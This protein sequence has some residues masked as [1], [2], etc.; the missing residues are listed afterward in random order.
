MGNES[1]KYV[2]AGPRRGARNIA[3]ITKRQR[4]H[5]NLVYS[6]ACLCQSPPNTNTNSRYIS[7]TDQERPVE[8]VGSAP[9][10]SIGGLDAGAHPRARN[11]Q[12]PVESDP[13]SIELT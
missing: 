10:V 9:K 1:Q 3:C 5:T 2:V 7:K 12:N 6:K 4:P 11:C 8:G 13:G